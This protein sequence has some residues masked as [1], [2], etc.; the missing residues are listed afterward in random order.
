[1]YKYVF[2]YVYIHTNKH[3]HIYRYA[4]RWE[5]SKGLHDVY[6]YTYVRIINKKKTLFKGFTRGDP[7]VSSL[8]KQ[9][10]NRT[11]KNKVGGPWVSPFMKQNLNGTLKHEAFTA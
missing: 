5:M 3:T 4:Y 6:T 1:M 7:W 9:N 11:Q 8:T 2:M 10:L